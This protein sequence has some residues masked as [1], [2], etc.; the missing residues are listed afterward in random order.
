MT[1]KLSISVPDDV[2]DW[3]GEQPNASAAVAA[4]VR[5][6]MSAARTDEVLRRAGIVVTEDG[7]ARWRERLARPMPAE[8]LDEGRRLL[9]G[10]A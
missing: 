4:A 3:L 6:Q 1:A 10:M 8:V 2:A 5:A 7:K 9:E